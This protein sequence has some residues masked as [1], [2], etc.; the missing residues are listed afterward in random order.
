MPT[1]TGSE[2]EC[3]PLTDTL[4]HNGKGMSPREEVFFSLVEIKTEGKLDP[5]L[6]SRFHLLKDND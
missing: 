6:N 4:Q 5:G 2:R 3:K 1:V